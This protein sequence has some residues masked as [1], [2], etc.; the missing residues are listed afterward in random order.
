M[1]KMMMQKAG[2][3]RLLALHGLCAMLRQS[4]LSGA[5][6]QVQMPVLCDYCQRRSPTDTAERDWEL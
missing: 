6:A 3:S 1:K 5:S 2:E 4:L